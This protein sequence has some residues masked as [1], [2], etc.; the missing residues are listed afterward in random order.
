MVWSIPFGSRLT[1]LDM[2]WNHHKWCRW[3]RWMVSRQRRRM[4][5]IIHGPDMLGKCFNY[6]WQKHTILIL[7][8]HLR[9]IYSYLSSQ[10]WS[11]PQKRTVTNMASQGLNSWSPQRW[12]QYL[13]LTSL[14]PRRVCS[15]SIDLQGAE[16]DLILASTVWTSLLW[17]HTLEAGYGWCFTFVSAV[18]WFKH[19]KTPHP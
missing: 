2:P 11:S 14:M 8:V 12:W 16:R 15:P 17:I 10:F 5:M 13:S 9:H 7:C 6:W 1:C 3:I 19:V 4:R 18:L